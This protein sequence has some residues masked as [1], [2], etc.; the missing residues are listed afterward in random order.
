MQKRKSKVHELSDSGSEDERS[1]FL[2]KH[3]SASISSAAAKKKTFIK[4]FLNMSSDDDSSCSKHNR[5]A[6]KTDSLTDNRES[7]QVAENRKKIEALKRQTYEKNKKT[8]SPSNSDKRHYSD[9][10]HKKNYSV[11]FQKEQNSV[12][13]TKHSQPE[14]KKYLSSKPEVSK[15][16]QMKFEND[17]KNSTSVSEMKHHNKQ[18]LKV[19]SPNV[20][21]KRKR[22]GSPVP[23]D[24]RKAVTEIMESEGIKSIQK[25]D[26]KAC[27]YGLKCYRKNPSH[28]E[29]F[30]HPRGNLSSALFGKCP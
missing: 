8:S 20:D 28:F 18:N 27:P 29:E 23:Q 1:D 30:S 4:E 5:S 13:D 7:E 9:K 16:D 11:P 14:V 19:S 21:L 24:L 10:P 12:Q 25:T 3:S 22:S 2:P 6:A 15:S 17:K 26:K